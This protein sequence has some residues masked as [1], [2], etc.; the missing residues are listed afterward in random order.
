MLSRLMCGQGK[1]PLRLL[2][3]V[4]VIMVIMLAIFIPVGGEDGNDDIVV[5]AEVNPPTIQ[6]GAAERLLIE[7]TQRDVN[8]GEKTTPTGNTSEAYSDAEG[9]VPQY[10]EGL[11]QTKNGLTVGLNSPTKQ[12]APQAYVVN[13]LPLLENEYQD[14]I[15]F[16]QKDLGLSG[17]STPEDYALQQIQFKNTMM[18]TTAPSSFNSSGLHGAVGPAVTVRNYDVVSYMADTSQFRACF[19]GDKNNSY[20]DAMLV[21]TADVQKYLAGGDVDVT[22][23]QF[24]SNDAKGHAYPWG[25]TQ[26]YI[27]GTKHS[28][29]SLHLGLNET[30]GGNSKEPPGAPVVVE[31]N[32][33]NLEN[34]WKQASSSGKPY[35][36][37]PGILA[38][39]SDLNM[40]LGAT[41]PMPSATSSILE[42]YKN[43]AS[44]ELKADYTDYS[45]VGILVY[46][47]Q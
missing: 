22:Y 16:E 14:I 1:S 47:I 3:P 39:A 45:L 37:W 32:V 19:G 24:L 25:I 4:F 38:T 27:F 29:G 34:V 5:A 35:Y 2:L 33:K 6:S 12:Y 13:V 31:D 15:S 21:K 11:V 46:A 42:C 41:S 30:S 44:D 43:S 23:V 10:S 26:T 8:D 20:M 36:W 40:T 28:D 18:F 17:H 7:S 9:V